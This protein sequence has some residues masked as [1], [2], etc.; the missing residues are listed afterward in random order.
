VGLAGAAGVTAGGWA[1]QAA[2]LPP[3]TSAARVAADASSWFHEYRLVVDVFHF[4]HHRE[5]GACLRGWFG[6]AHGHK[7]RASVLSLD[8]GTILRTLPKR[9]IGLVAGHPDRRLPGSLA[10]AAGCSRELASTLA[11]AAQ[12]GA[13]MTV[14]RAYAAN[15]PAIALR[16]SRGNDRRLT[17]YVAPRTDRPLVTIVALAD[18]EATARLYLSR[19]EPRLLAHFHLP[20]EAGRRPRA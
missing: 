15:Q 16:V 9:R 10:L 3:P 17:L 20:P 4:D 2:A 6:R 8:S 14:S 1:L 7:A 5:G 13:H 19:A 18:H 12:S 11:R